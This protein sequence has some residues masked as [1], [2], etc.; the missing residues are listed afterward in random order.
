VGSHSAQPLSPKNGQAV[1]PEKDGEL[2]WNVINFGRSFQVG[3]VRS[4]IRVASG[5]LVSGRHV[6]DRLHIELLVVSD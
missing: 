4:R 2:D 3:R 6:S 1:E 5:R